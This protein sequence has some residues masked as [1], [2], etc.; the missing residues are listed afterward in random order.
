MERGREW[1]GVSQ[2]IPTGRESIASN[3]VKLDD[4]NPKGFHAQLPSISP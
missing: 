3:V 2:E 1:N 4:N